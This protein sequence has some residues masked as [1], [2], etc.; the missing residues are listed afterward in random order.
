L[1]IKLGFSLQAD[2]MIKGAGEKS[3]EENGRDRDSRNS[4]IMMIR[5]ASLFILFI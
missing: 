1:G 3:A 4:R 5:C 2:Y